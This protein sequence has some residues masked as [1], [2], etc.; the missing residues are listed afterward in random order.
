M[1]KSVII[2]TSL[3]SVALIVICTIA[4]TYSV[5]INVVEK[6]GLTEIINEITI[7]DLFITDQGN[8][9]STY[10]NVKRELNITDN[11]AEL[12][13]TSL[14]LN[15]ALKNILNSIVEYKLH[16]NTTARKSN[17]EI[18]NLIVTSINETINIDD[19][20]KNKVITKSNYYKQDISDFIYNIDVKLMD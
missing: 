3:I 13:M 16:N 14:P 12:L 4:S 5:I 8:F 7:K 10:Y 18:Y 9:N 6:D 1:K 2:I 11:E 15:K 19:D 20:L 17:E